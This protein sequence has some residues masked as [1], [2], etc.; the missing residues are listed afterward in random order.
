[1]QIILIFFRPLYFAGYDKMMQVVDWIEIGQKI[2]VWK[3]HFLK[4]VI[5]SLPIFE[6]QTDFRL[7]TRLGG[8]EVSNS[9]LDFDKFS[10]TLFDSISVDRCYQVIEQYPQQL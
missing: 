7:F 8:A 10:V 1:M 5:L 3:S 2:L 6:N 9:Q 4:D